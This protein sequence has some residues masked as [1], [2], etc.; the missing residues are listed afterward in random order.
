M[1]KL[2]LGFVKNS[3]S[4]Y[5]KVE[6]TEWHSLARRTAL[7]TLSFS[8]LHS[9]NN[10]TS[11]KCMR[12]IQQQNEM[13]KTVNQG[14]TLAWTPSYRKINPTKS[15]TG[16]RDHCHSLS[17][18]QCSRP[19][20]SCHLSKTPSD[21][22]LLVLFRLNWRIAKS[23]ATE[24]TQGYLLHSRVK[25]AATGGSYIKIRKAIGKYG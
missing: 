3:R 12:K 22:L 16:T 18:F 1:L 6:D 25:I 24:F 14:K 17:P 4:L 13:G 10:T 19:G 15:E 7:A 8:L 20:D 5:Y 9:Y 11:E 21:I 23:A 2:L